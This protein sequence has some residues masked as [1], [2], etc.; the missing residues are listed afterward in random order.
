MED[1]QYN[2]IREQGEYF[3][4][5]PL[6]KEDNEKVNRAEENKDEKK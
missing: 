2:I 4:P 3:D 5:V 1:K 6:S